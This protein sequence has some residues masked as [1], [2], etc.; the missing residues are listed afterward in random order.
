MDNLESGN[1]SRAGWKRHLADRL[2]A[3]GHRNWICVVDSAYPEQVAS[4]IEIVPTG[5]DHIT[6]V[7][8]VLEAVGA[9]PH[10]RAVVWL[11]AELR[12]LDDKIAPGVDAFRA[13]LNL[14]LKDADVKSLPHEDIIKM[15]DQAGQAFHVLVFKSNL[16]LPYTSLFLQ[17][18]CGYWD[19]GSEEALRQIMNS[20]LKDPVEE[21]K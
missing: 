16:T 3:L 5:C 2:P 1:R 19:A 18:E 21:G 13:Q 10:V 17:L 15:L 8:V 14:A 4:G 9:A 7:D 20:R 12:H 6:V 11:D